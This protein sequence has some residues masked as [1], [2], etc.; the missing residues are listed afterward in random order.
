LAAPQRRTRTSARRRGAPAPERGT[1]QGRRPPRLLLPPP[2]R[3]GGPGGSGLP[4]QLRR[5]SGSGCDGGAGA[6]RAINLILF[7]KSQSKK[8]SA[9][10]A[11]DLHCRGYA[12]SQQAPLR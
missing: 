11:R 8:A 12:D 4:P 6:V 9:G 2:W 5:R 3:P 10:R 7:K 1:A